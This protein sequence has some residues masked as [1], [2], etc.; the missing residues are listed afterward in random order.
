[1]KGWVPEKLALSL[2]LSKENTTF[3]RLRFFPKQGK[4]FQRLFWSLKGWVP[5]KFAQ[6]LNLSK[7]NATFERLR[8]FPK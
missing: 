5:E 8:S 3:E 7:E 2:N 6:S 1:L 4:T